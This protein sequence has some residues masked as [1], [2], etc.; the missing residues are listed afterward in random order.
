VGG[1]EPDAVALHGPEV[2][3]LQHHAPHRDRL[4]PGVEVARHWQVLWTTGKI[5]PFRTQHV[6]KNG[7]QAVSVTHQEQGWQLQAAEV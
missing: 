5:D 2:R 3:R 4:V 6:L 1:R 7:S